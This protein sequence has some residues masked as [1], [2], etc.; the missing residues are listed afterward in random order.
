[1]VIISRRDV[2]DIAKSMVKRGIYNQRSEIVRDAVR[3]LAFRYSLKVR[4]LDEVRGIVH[5]ASKKSEES[6]SQAVMKI[7]EEAT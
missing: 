3:Q 5:K 4:S 7:R 2:R 1:M 6:L